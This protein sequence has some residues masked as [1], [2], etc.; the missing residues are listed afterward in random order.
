MYLLFTLSVLNCKNADPDPGPITPPPTTVNTAPALDNAATA[1][2]PS[3]ITTE[4]AKVSSTLTANGGAAITQY[5]HVWSDTKADPTTADPKTELGKTDGPFP[6]KFTSDLK[7]LKAN[8]TYNVRAYATNDKGTSYGAAVQVKTVTA[9]VVT[10]SKAAKVIIVLDSYQAYAIN[11]SDQT[12]IWTK[13][14]S[15][16]SGLGASTLD[17]TTA[18]ISWNNGTEAYDIQTGVKKWEFT[19]DLKERFHTTPLI[20]NDLLIVGTSDGSTSNVLYALEIKTGKKKWEY[21]T[22]GNSISSPTIV[23]DVLYYGANQVYA[24]NPNSGTKLWNFALPSGSTSSPAVS[25]GLVYI[26]ANNGF[27]YALDSK[28]GTK[29][30]EFKTGGFFLSSSPSVSDGVVFV[31]ATDKKVYALD[32]TTGIKKWEFLTGE[33][34]LSSPWVENGFVYIGSNDKKLY[35]LDASTGTKRWEYTMN[36]QNTSPNTSPAVVNDVVYMSSNYDKKLYAI[37][38]KTGAKIWESPY[39]NSLIS[40]PSILTN[41]GKTVHSGISGTRQ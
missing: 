30:W 12:K 23:D 7:S 10:N 27:F 13:V 38:A 25:N 32:A 24:L 40:S 22:N 16:E 1:T 14:R 5:G 31:G 8:T 33:S 3:D 20:Y 18:Y 21:K 6:L 11:A 37:N 35:A 4:T 26:G 9:P 34:V 41:D 39:T 15:G 36:L 17:N 29:K 19:T 2:T 28:T